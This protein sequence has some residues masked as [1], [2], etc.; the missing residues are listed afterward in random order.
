MPE[1]K[2]DSTDGTEQVGNSYE[3]IRSRLLKSAEALKERVDN[4][5]ER[6]AESFGGQ[7]LILLGGERVRT[8][9]NCVPRDIVQV[10]GQLL[11]G[12]NV[13]IGLKSETSIQDVFSLHRFLKSEAGVEL[14]NVALTEES[15]AF[16]SARDFVRDFAELYGFYKEA[17]LLQLARSETRLLAIFQIGANLADRRVFRWEIDSLG[18]PT[19]LDNRGERDHVRPPKYD[20]EWVPT[21]REDHVAGTHPHVSIL[22]Q[23]FVETVGG[24]L[25]IKVEN[26]TEDGEGIYREPVDVANQALDDAQIEYAKVGVLILLRVLPYSESKWRYLVFSTRSHKVVRI[27][28]LALACTQLPEDHGILFP[29]GY[30]LQD[31]QFK[32]FDGDFE[33]FTFERAVRAP[34]GEDVLYVFHR[35]TDGGYRLL[36][37]NL[38]RKEIA[39]PIACNGFSLFDDGRLIVFKATSDEPTRV[40]NMQ[41]WQTPYLSAEHAA[42][43]PKVEGMLGKVGN[44]ELVRGISDAYTV[45]RQ[46]ADTK[47]TRLIYEDLV[48]ATTR[49][50][51]HYYWLNEPEVGMLQDILLDIRDTGELIIDEFDKVVAMRAQADRQLADASALHERRLLDMRPETW[52]TVSQFMNS[53]AELRRATGQWVTLREVR[54]IDLSRIE[55]LEAQTQD[56]FNSISKDA[57]RFLLKDTALLPL[58]EQLNALLAEID[59]AE[60]TTVLKELEQRVQQTAEGLTVLSEVV[61]GLQVDDPTDRTAILERISGVFASL[62]RVRATLR[63]RSQHIGSVESA[64][65]FAAQL[66]LLAQSVANGLSQSDTPERCDEQHGRLMAQ[67]EELEARFGEYD[68]YLSEL[69]EKRAEV[70]DAL[71]SRKQELVD[72]R[73]RSAQRVGEAA[74]RIVASI[75]R[76][77]L[78]FASTE[79]L[80]T[81]FA[82]DSMVVRVREMVSRLQSLGDA[83]RSDEL[84]S[85][86]KT[87]K[88][89]SV[90]AVRD[91]IELTGGDGK[92]IALGAHRFT[93]NTQHL[94]LTMLGDS[95]GM[96]FVLTGTDYA[97]RVED[98]RFAE[99][100]QYWEQTTVSENAEVY[101]AEYLADVVLG[102]VDSSDAPFT[103]RQLHER[104]L[105]EGGLLEV[106]REVATTRYDEAYDRG[107][108]D[109]DAARILDQLLNLH[110]RAGLLSVP[111]VDRALACLLWADLR[112]EQRRK[113][114]AL[115]AKSLG[116]LRHQYGDQNAMVALVQ[117]IT[118]VV[119]TFQ[120][121]LGLALAAAN[122]VRAARYLAREL[123]EPETRFV[124]A[125]GAKLL[126][127]TLLADAAAA[128]VASTSST[129]GDDLDA[130]GGDLRARLE[131]ALAWSRAFA[132]KN[133]KSEDLA[134]EAAILLL[135]EDKVPRFESGALV[136]GVVGGLLGQHPRLKEQRICI[137]LDEFVPRLERFRSTVV[138]GFRA[139]KTARQELVDAQRK[140]L[141]LD[142][143]KPRV[144]S[145]FV[146]NRLINE[147]YLPLVGDNLAKQLGAAGAGKRTDL[148]GLLLLIS[149]PGYGKTTLM[150]YLASKLGLV[151]LKINGPAL[152]HSVVSLDPSEA[153]NATAR[154]EVEKINLGFEMGNNVMLYLDDIQHTNPE[155]LQK[156]ISLCDAQRRV[157][158]VWRG[159]ARTYDLRGKKFCVVMAG[160]PY[161]ESGGRFQIPDMLANRADTYNLGD[162]LDGKDDVFALSY[163]E[164]AITS[165]PT[166][167]VLSMREQRDLYSFI[168]RSEGSEVH[169]S[170]FSHDYSVVESNEIV[171]VLKHMFAVQRVL[172]LVNQEYIRSASMDDRY[173][174]EPPFK[175]QGSYRNMNKLAEKIV[176]AMNEREVESLIDDHYNGEAQ[177]L[178]T[179]AEQNL[180]KLAELRG[181]LNAKQSARWEDIKHEFA[182]VNRLG[183]GDQ[184]P[185]AHVASQLSMLEEQLSAI[186][187]A[188]GTAAKTGSD[189]PEVELLSQY[190]GKLSETIEREA[191]R[192]VEIRVQNEAPPGVEELL[193]QQAYVLEH[194]LV[195]FVKV[196]TQRLDDSQALR[197]RLDEFIASLKGLDLRLRER[198]GPV[199]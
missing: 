9:N 86:L 39:T 168:R 64:A 163:I 84:E 34:N 53:L 63:G 19:Y 144:L 150:E 47:P 32:V 85:K 7:A 6:R 5:N 157:E 29:G 102:L 97:E 135:T 68:E 104:R 89:D 197:E 48:R 167:S 35:P 124:T 14:G 66:T 24:D 148:M 1:P 123:S 179:G 37:Y 8:E 83:T 51:D 43:A 58:Q 106:V 196:A 94:E 70:Y 109:A 130:L 69:T 175:L 44:A 92:L 71:N 128:P 59:K 96:R 93:V 73:Q 195:P 180:L 146:R 101:R 155:F 107:V 133:G 57:I 80:N 65:E 42:A 108:H 121:S 13:F 103:L 171:A 131:L 166:L 137:K 174:M 20:F 87:A 110:E 154:Q 17:R 11:F 194:T 52:S 117:E 183:G 176:P 120:H 142:E 141:R 78:E 112:D 26:N 186:A 164:N 198:L 182:R 152:G 169:S 159:T 60:K 62:N 177:T 143:F 67:L 156:F 98:A 111:T 21:A 189:R 61:A 149:P 178:T 41:V 16:L 3:V 139:Y 36:S 105:R 126:K 127:D 38:V 23:V 95:E 184:D 147:V 114:W 50:V 191:E 125:A 25:T 100:R 151:F 54:Y 138:P 118:A 199:R 56:L 145:S 22:D 136:E 15:A 30:F 76:R 119:A 99:T 46:I 90:R 10:S 134:L 81:F 140:A 12:F 45:I 115:R 188:I 28:Q 91:R 161:T 82:S 88:Q 172:L 40:H 72:A 2:F 190:L 160:N 55:A 27:D 187:S 77:A 185:V 158:G 116:R 75:S 173:R 33:G 132:A 170:D 49:M 113:G 79:E 4:L 31:S 181:K 192:I 165:S 122:P 18:K 193:K 162:I 129:L 74:D 153:P